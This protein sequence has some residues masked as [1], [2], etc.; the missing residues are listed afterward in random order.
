M[1]VKTIS[2]SLLALLLMGSSA[3]ANV[4]DLPNPW[5]EQEGMAVPSETVQRNEN[6]SVVINSISRKGGGTLYKVNLSPA[7]AVDEITL[8]TIA[9]KLT[10]LSTT[11]ILETGEKVELKSLGKISSLEKGRAPVSEK[12]NLSKKIKQIEV[13]AES[14]GSEAD[15]QLSLNS[16]S[17]KSSLALEKNKVEAVRSEKEDL[18]LSVTEALSKK[19]LSDDLVHLDKSVAFFSFNNEVL[20]YPG[21]DKASLGSSCF[22]KRTGSLDKGVRV[23][24]GRLFKIHT[25]ATEYPRIYHKATKDSALGIYC[26]TSSGRVSQFAKDLEG[27]ARLSFEVPSFKSLTGNRKVSGGVKVSVAEA[28][29][30]GFQKAGSLQTLSELKVFVTMKKTIL[31]SPRVDSVEVGSGCILKRTKETGINKALRINAGATFQIEMTG[32]NHPRMYTFENRDKEAFGIY[33]DSTEQSVSNFL[34]LTSSV[35]NVFVMIPDAKSFDTW[36]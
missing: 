20:F 9:G 22:A 23:Q 1:H 4:I 28:R 30:R 35:W 32:T 16:V 18:I 10:V 12:T 5:E 11:V 2:K 29:Q 7:I 34:N 26:E 15:L 25:S 6:S 21:K 19:Y 3:H 31:L 33:C 36:P 24:A 8:T 17:G 14:Q 13:L 27:I